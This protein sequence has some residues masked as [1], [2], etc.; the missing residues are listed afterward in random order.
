MYRVSLAT[1]LVA[2]TLLVTGCTGSLRLGSS[3]P[4]VDAGRTTTNV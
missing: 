2:V 1:L 4:V 3:I